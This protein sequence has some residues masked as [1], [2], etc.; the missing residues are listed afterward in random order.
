MG[1]YI[2][3]MPMWD[4]KHGSVVIFYP[5]GVV[6]CEDGNKYKAIEVPDHGELVDKNV[7]REA[8]DNLWD[9]RPLS[10]IGARVLATIYKVPSIIPADTSAT[11]FSMDMPNK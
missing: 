2:Q 8:V 5:Q 4:K 1:V 11:G 7:V 6:I 9:G 3:G 10:K